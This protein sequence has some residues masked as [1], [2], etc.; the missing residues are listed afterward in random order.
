VALLGT[1]R[2][3]VSVTGVFALR[4]IGLAGVTVH[5]APGMA[6]ALQVALMEPV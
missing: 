2:V 6:L 5:V 3:T 1:P 4:E